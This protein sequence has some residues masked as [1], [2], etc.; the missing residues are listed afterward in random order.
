MT[1]IPH[2]EELPVDNPSS[3]AFAATATS[4]A[5]GEAPILTVR[6]VS[7]VFRRGGRSVT[8]LAGVDLQA[9]EGEFVVVIGPSGCGKS[10]LLH[11]LGGFETASSGEVVVGGTV[12]REPGRDRG[13]VFQKATLFPWWT[14]ERNVAWPLEV[15]G[16]TRRQCRERAGELLDLVGLTGFADAYPGELSGG[17]QQRAGIA[18]TL[19][20]EPN[21]LL[22]DEPF[23]A[24]DAQTRELMQEELN[25]IWQ[26][27][28][29]TVVFITHDINEAVFLGDRVLVMSGRPGSIIAD[30]PIDLPRPRDNDVKGSQEFAGYHARLWSLLRD[31]AIAAEGVR[32]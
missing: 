29:I 10:T 11:V 22:M 21:V 5:H 31:E 12:V 19:A 24:L 18:R 3:G 4:A 8:A 27:A 15:A 13:M 30:V 28:G 25:R 26:Q 17:M 23:G 16:A 1:T 20:L 2:T 9:R 32:K 7:K 6:G 14:I